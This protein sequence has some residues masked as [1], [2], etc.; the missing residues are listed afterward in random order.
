MAPPT[1]LYEYYTSQGQALPSVQARKTVASQAG[2]ANYSGTAQ[3]NQQLLSYLTGNKQTVAPSTP[4]IPTANATNIGNTTPMNIPAPAPQPNYNSLVASFAQDTQQAQN[5]QNQAQQGVQDSTNALI[6][7][8]K[9]LE[10]QTLEQ[11]QLEQQQGVPQINQDL[12]DLQNQARQRN[13]QYQQQFVTAEGKPV[14]MDVIVGEQAQLQ[15]QNAIDI[16][17]INSNIQAKQGQLGLAQAT[18]QSAL[19]AKYEPIKAQIETQKLILDSNYK[20]LSSAEKKLA[21]AKQTELSLRLKQIDEQKQ[22]ET[23]IYN[24]M[25]TAAQNGATSSILNKISSTANMSD[26]LILAAP[27]LNDPI[28]KQIKLATLAEKKA[29]TAKINAEKKAI[30]NTINTINSIDPLASDYTS[31]LIQAS[32]GGKQLTGEQTTPITK[33]LTVVSQIGNLQTILNGQNTG[34]IIGIL[35][36]N[37][38]YDIKARQI[39]AQLQAIVPNLA[40]GIYGEVGVL[41][42]QDIANYS[43]TLGNIK[44][45]EQ[46]NNLLLSMTLK[47]IKNSLDNQFQVLAASGRDVSGFSGIYS[48]LQTKINSIDDSLGVGDDAVNSYLDQSLGNQKSSGALDTISNWLNSNLYKK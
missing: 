11:Q 48:N 28:D 36:S 25:T 42:D 3:Q 47:T 30:N 9:Q 24:L 6:T 12:L 7:L 41:T 34:P 15:R 38:P 31:Q 45:P 19:N 46:A 26:A 44:T 14:P 35:R 40:R 5:Q 29:S 23:D 13:L 16:A 17:L 43:K 39:S 27:Y 22:N 18:V 10:G 2:I 20:L 33:G 1:N 8:S 21:D 4:V 37:N 32:K